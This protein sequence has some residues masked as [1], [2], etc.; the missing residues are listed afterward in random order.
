MTK[1][2]MPLLINQQ[3]SNGANKPSLCLILT[4]NTAEHLFC[5]EISKSVYEKFLE[6]W[7]IYLSQ[8]ELDNAILV[9]IQKP[10]QF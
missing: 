5:P 6:P 4:T 8:G 10:E 9:L 3:I 1:Q 7:V 2:A